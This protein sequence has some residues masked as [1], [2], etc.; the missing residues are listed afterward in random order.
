MLGKINT[1]LDNLEGDNG[2]TTTKVSKHGS[3]PGTAMGSYEGN[4]DDLEGRINN[5]E[6]NI[7]SILQDIPMIS[8]NK[9]K[10]QEILGKISNQ[11]SSEEVTKL[12]H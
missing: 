10:I 5:I 3:K 1:R 9:D 2:L 8:S 4:P 7:D 6:V 12:K 11:L